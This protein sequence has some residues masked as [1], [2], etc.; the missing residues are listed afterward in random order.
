MKPDDSTSNFYLADE[1]FLERVVRYQ[2]ASMSTAE[3]AAFERELL[4]DVDKQRAFADLQWRS[5]AVRHAFQ[6]Q[7]YEDISAKPVPIKSGYTLW[8]VAGLLAMAASLVGV[9]FFLSRQSLIPSNVTP[10]FRAGRV[11]QSAELTAESN[12]PAALPSVRTKLVSLP[13]ATDSSLSMLWEFSAEETTP[14]RSVGG[15]HRD[16]P[17]PR[18]PDYPDFDESNTAVKLD[19]RGARL[20]F[21]DSGPNSRFDF[22]NGDTITLEAWVQVDELRKNEN[23]YVV[24]KGRTGSPGFPDDNQNWALRVKEGKGKA[25]VSFLF[26]TSPAGRQKSSDGHWHRWTTDHGF[27][28]G[29]NWHHIAVT[30]LFGEPASI[31]VW[32]D[33]EVQKGSWDMGGPTIEPPIVDD[34]AI[35]IGS[36]RSGAA[37]NSFRGVL[38]S[39]AVHRRALDEAVMASRFRSTVRGETKEQP[40][41]APELMPL[42]NDVPANQVLLTLH[43]AMPSHTRWLNEGEQFPEESIRFQIDHSLFDRLPIRWDDWGIRSSWKTPVLARLACDLDLSAGTHKF[44]MRVRGLSRLWVDEQLIAKAGPITKSPS[45]EE[46]MTP[47]AQPPLPGLRRAEHRQQE[48][49]G[50]V[51]FTESG[52]HRVVLETLVGGKPQRPDPGEILVAIQSHDS[53]TFYVLSPKLR[54]AGLQLTDTE[55]ESALEQLEKS[56]TAF[57]DHYRRQASISQQAYWQR[58]HAIAKEFL[59]RQNRATLKNKELHPID[60]FVQE[61]I[62]RA[63]AEAAKSSAEQS[64]YFH[65]QILPLLRDHCFRCHGDKEQSGLRLDSR[66]ALLK[67]G[68]SEAVAV[69]PGQPE[70]SEIIRRIRSK[71]DGERMPPGGEGLSDEQA[72]ILES[73]IADG[74]QWPAPMV[75]TEVSLPAKILSDEAYLRRVTLDTIGLV[76]S[77][78]E[79]Q[80]FSLDGRPNKRELAIDRLLADERWADH[81]MSYWQ[82]VLAENPTLLNA[83]LNTTGPFRWFL[84]DAFHDNKPMDRIVTELI[85]M[86]GD[87]YEGGSAGFAIAGDNDAPLAAKGQIIAGAFLGIELQCARCHDSPYH[88]TTQRDL[89]ALAAMLDRKPSKVPK[90]SRVP[91]AF[92]EKKAR[93]SLI[94]VTLKPDEAV[95]PRWPFESIIPPADEASIEELLQNPSDSR[96]RLAALVTAPFNTRFASVVVNRMWRRYLG[97]G[98][99]EPPHDWEGSAPSHPEL[100]SWLADDFV[101]HGYDLKHL[102][103]RILTSQ[104]YQRVPEG[105]NREAAPEVRYFA[106]PDRRRLTAEQIVDSLFAAAGQRMNVEEMTFDPDGRREAKNRL[107]LGTPRRAWMFC[108]LANERDRPSLALPKAGMVAD[109]LEAFG[110]SG[111]RQSPRTDREGDPNV[112]QPG[113]LANSHFSV[114]L[115]R[116]SQ[117][118][119]LSQLAFESRTPEELLDRLFLRF[120]GRR[121][122]E[123]ERAPLLEAIAKGFEDRLLPEA[124]QASPAEPDILPKVTWSNHLRSE[125]NL[126]ALEME[127]R[128]RL[129]PPVD[130]RL[131]PEWREIVEDVVWSIINT[132]EFVWMP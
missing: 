131:R 75:P 26:A 51:T 117:G 70:A 31:K 32:I 114:A 71:D 119:E 50:E 85:L 30:Y 3:Q 33:S 118:S 24:G 72:S 47:V 124:A 45:G 15:V 19:G 81:Q 29:P 65:G 125:A 78:V 126:I 18:S 101:S 35:W 115:T 93:E 61:K 34:D 108:N 121:P 107:T 113:V 109:V 16:V 43:E 129:G 8:P 98:I 130:P 102:T 97:A 5:A 14:L 53:P 67:A 122:S 10:S 46:P 100:L 41:P 1:S 92:F 77:E 87:A 69:V 79:I 40:K 120:L 132:R 63:V 22:T 39:V 52:R 27:A 80:A 88:S 110:W 106:M 48:V 57:D 2:D 13:V 25:C 20:E 9:G 68:D 127:K 99:V 66:E 23:V 55:V 76:P 62:E 84:Y 95:E 54:S 82:D 73:W 37:A 96:E 59:Q 21:E 94:K 49:F 42:V 105:D 86:R 91:S 11:D 89:Y 103:R 112:L 123:S 104:L 64:A 60:G 17:G 7:A 111:A 56:L 128:S 90:T 38:D 74:A 44:L 58:R 4:D 36:S 116:L 12:I 83:S 28:P 6:R